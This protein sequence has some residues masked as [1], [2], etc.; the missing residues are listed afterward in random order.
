MKKQITQSRYTS[1]SPGKRVL[2]GAILVTFLGNFSTRAQAVELILGQN[3]EQ[4]VPESEL[5]DSCAEEDP[6]SR[7]EIESLST[8]QLEDSNFQ[9]FVVWTPAAICAVGGEGVAAPAAGGGLPPI[10]VVASGGG[11][12]PYEALGGLGLIPLLAFLPGSDG[13][14]SRQPTQ[15]EPV[16]EPSAILGSGVALGFGFLLQRNWLKRQRRLTSHDHH[17]R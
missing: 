7:K 17:P 15:P 4:T 3:P 13:E 5:S 12:F 9:E 14:S 6:L 1:N 8:G 11:G 16:P 2:V 10:P